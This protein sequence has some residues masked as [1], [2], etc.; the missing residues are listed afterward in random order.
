MLPVSRITPEV[1]EVDSEVGR[2]ATIPAESPEIFRNSLARGLSPFRQLGVH[3]QGICPMRGDSGL[4]K[5]LPGGGGGWGRGAR[6]HDWLT[7]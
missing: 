1:L 5:A 7:D 6:S 2:L 4:A 3:L